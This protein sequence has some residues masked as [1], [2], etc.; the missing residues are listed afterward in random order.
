MAGTKRIAGRSLFLCTVLMIFVLFAGCGTREAATPE[1]FKAAVQEAGLTVT[2]RTGDD[3]M[4]MVAYLTASDAEDPSDSTAHCQLVVFP[5][6]SQ[7]RSYYA[8]FLSN[9]QGLSPKVEKQIDTDTYNKYIVTFGEDY[10][11]LV[12]IGAS[13]FYG[14]GLNKS[15]GANGSGTMRAI[16]EKLHYN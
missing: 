9:V 8:Q 5:D 6:A 16:V 14:E 3:L 1:E 10:C 15:E 12:R 11:A 13:V 7:A 2:E 4:G